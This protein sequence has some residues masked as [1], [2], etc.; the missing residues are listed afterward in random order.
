MT[1]LIFSVTMGALTRLRLPKLAGRESVHL[2]DRGVPYSG[3]RRNAASVAI[4]CRMG[5]FE[6]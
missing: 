4:E 5:H 3:Q 2:V 1:A 6:G